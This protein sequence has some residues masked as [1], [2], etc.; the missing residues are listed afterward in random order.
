MHVVRAAVLLVPAVLLPAA[1]C[2][3]HTA[4]RA[5][6]MRSYVVG[7][8]AVAAQ[9]LPKR[10]DVKEIDIVPYDMDVGMLRHVSGD[11]RGADQAL[12]RAEQ[13]IDDLFT[14][15]VS[16]KIG[17][18]FWNDSTKSYA[19]EEF[20]RIMVNVVRGYNFLMLNDIEKAAVE[21]RK[22]SKKLQQY[23][24][25]IKSFEQGFKYTD[26]GWAHYMAALTAEAFQD[27]NAALVSYRNAVRAYRESGAAFG[28]SAPPALVADALRAVRAAG[29]DEGEISQ[30]F[31]KVAPAAPL[32]DGEG[33]L[34]VVAGVGH[35]AFKVSRSWKVSDPQ[36]DIIN[37]TYPEFVRRNFA[38]GYVTASVNGGAEARTE[39]AD[40]VSNIAVQV[41]NDRNVGVKEEAIA[42]AIALYAAKKAARA[43]A[44]SD[45]M[46]AW[47]RLLG[48]AV[49]IAA[50]VRDI[51]EV[52]DTRSWQT[53]PD[54]YQIARLR[55]PAGE[56]TLQLRVYGGSGVPMYALPPRT[57]RVPS[58]GRVFQVLHTHEVSVPADWVSQ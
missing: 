7:N 42:R 11:Y 33:E 28:M 6:F 32:A 30:H 46:P 1:G 29:V 12:D 45:R 20:E 56:H 26:D 15:S 21:F 13:K 31:P 55:L 50:N 36:G 3:S 54:T 19:G 39:V 57:V 17:A 16:E 40:Q 34:V 2:A 58:K 23:G 4:Q 27:E 18:L 44:Q 43:V 38:A 9:A 14:K 41:L 53:L 48:A 49:N 10:E 22:V 25:R 47:A 52:A 24:D 37:V 51:L 5:D 8:Y 35:V